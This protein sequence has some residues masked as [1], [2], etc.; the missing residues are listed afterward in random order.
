MHQHR[1][2]ESGSL[3]D[4]HERFKVMS[5]GWYFAVREGKFEGPFENVLEAKKA[6]N[7]YL[8]RMGIVRQAS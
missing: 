3:P 6:L 4:R 8:R 1:R 7:L 2:G 5:N